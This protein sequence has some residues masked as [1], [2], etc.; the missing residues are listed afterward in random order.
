MRIKV[1]ILVWIWLFASTVKAMAAPSPHAI[2]FGKVTAA[3]WFAGP[4]GNTPVD[5]KV[6]SLYVDARPKE[7]TTG[8]AH[9]VTDRLSVVQRAFRLND[10]LPDETGNATRWPWQRRGWLMVDRLTGRG[11]P[12]VRPEFDPLYSTTT[13]YRDYV[14]YS[15]VSESGKKNICPGRPMGTPPANPE[16]DDGRSRR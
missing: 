12:I 15:R 4:D 2:P 5:L 8:A 16:E 1:H 7:Y 3:K 10:T 13:W 11:A 14:A 6:R 9:D